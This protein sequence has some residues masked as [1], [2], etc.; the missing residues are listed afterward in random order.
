M[1]QDKIFTP[2]LRGSVSKDV[3]SQIE[4]AI[5]SGIFQPGERL[6]SERDLQVQFH[7]SRGVVRE[8][9]RALQQKGLI[10]VKKGAKGGAYIKRVDVSKASESLALLLQQQ[11]IPLEYL[12]EFR[13]SIDRTVTE[14]AIARGD[15]R[16]KQRLLEGSALLE[17]AL[18]RPEPDM[19]VVHEIDRELN[20]LLVKMTKNPVFEWVAMTVQLGFGS[21]DHALYENPNYRER[22]AVNWVDTAREIADGETLKALSHISYH[23]L[24]LQRCLRENAARN[25][26]PENQAGRESVEEESPS[27]TGVGPDASRGGPSE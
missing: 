7:T 26:P 19:E 5:L 18:T 9:L 4:A 14:L 6:P 22:T 17:T 1:N 27:E 8:A 21:Y 15:D 23:Y 13:E 2:V 10:E 20:M 12:I 16:E 3:I 24:L 25:A 11:C